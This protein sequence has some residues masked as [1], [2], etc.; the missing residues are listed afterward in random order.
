[1]I[2]H[3]QSCYSA[4]L[5]AYF[6]QKLSQQTTSIQPKNTRNVI[7]EFLFFLF[8]QFHNIQIQN[9]PIYIYCKIYRQI[10][11]PSLRLAQVFSYSRRCLVLLQADQQGT[12]NLL[13]RTGCKCFSSISIPLPCNEWS[14][15]GSVFTVPHF[16]HVPSYNKLKAR[17]LKPDKSKGQFSQAP[18]RRHSLR[19]PTRPHPVFTRNYR[20]SYRSK[21]LFSLTKIAV[22]WS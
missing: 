20:S 5:Y 13:H 19:Y 14:M 16:D 22:L 3:F 10:A 4:S 15:S 1:M 12:P 6:Y 21:G 11:T 7:I 17:A 8:F 18:L 9:F 2:L